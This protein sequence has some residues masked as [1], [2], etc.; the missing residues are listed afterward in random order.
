MKTFNIKL[1]GYRLLQ[2]RLSPIA[3][4]D[5]SLLKFKKEW[6]EKGKLF[7]YFHL[8]LGLANSEARLTKV[9]KLIFTWDYNRMIK[10]TD[11]FKV[12]K[13]LVFYRRSYAKSSK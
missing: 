1:P 12:I 6:T 5:V 8:G 10:D 4:F 7:V 3:F 13:E 9:L 2:I 11:R